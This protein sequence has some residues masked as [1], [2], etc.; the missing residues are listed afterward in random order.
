[1]QTRREPIELFSVV[2]TGKSDLTRG[3]SLEEIA[4]IAEMARALRAVDL[5]RRG[6]RM[7]AYIIAGIEPAD[8]YRFDEKAMA[9]EELRRKTF[10][11]RAPQSLSN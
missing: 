11:L 8:I 2:T 9:S 5:S 6:R 1:L 10:N 7:A 4:T 3:G